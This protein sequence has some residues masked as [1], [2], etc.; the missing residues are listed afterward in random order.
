MEDEITKKL[1]S[2]SAVINPN[3]S[4]KECKDIFLEYLKHF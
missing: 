2:Q 3:Y 4:E 1:E